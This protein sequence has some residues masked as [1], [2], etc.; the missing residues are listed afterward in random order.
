VTAEGSIGL[1]VSCQGYQ[2]SAALAR[3]VALAR[4][5]KRKSPIGF[6]GHKL[7]RDL[8]AVGSWHHHWPYHGVQLWSVMLHCGQ[9]ITAIGKDSTA[10]ETIAKS[11]N[12]E[13]S[14]AA[15]LSRLMRAGTSILVRTVEVQQISSSVPKCPANVRSPCH[16]RAPVGFRNPDQKSRTQRPRKAVSSPKAQSTSLAL[17]LCQ[18]HAG[19]VS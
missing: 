16:C 14:T 4:A 19:S 11:P 1:I 2:Q 12:E 17:V 6:L 7:R 9:G 15:R 10:I 18:G 3:V 8:Q 5:T 13:S